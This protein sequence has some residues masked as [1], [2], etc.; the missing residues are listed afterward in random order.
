MGGE[1]G[2]STGRAGQCGGWVGGRGVA[3]GR[4]LSG[5]RAWWGMAAWEVEGSG[6]WVV[7]NSEALMSE[8]LFVLNLSNML[9][10]DGLLMA[11]HMMGGGGDKNKREKKISNQ[12]YLKLNYNI[13]LSL[14]YYGRGHK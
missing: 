6:A 5:A 13:H 11:T 4:G 12:K 2:H 1:L 8:H 7:G 9:P 14:H 3:P 10:E